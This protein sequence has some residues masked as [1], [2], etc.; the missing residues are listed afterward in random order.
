MYRSF[1]SS[2]R[3]RICAIRTRAPTA[4]RASTRSDFSADPTTIASV[5]ATGKAK[6]VHDTGRPLRL[7]RLHPALVYVS[8]SIQKEKKIFLLL[9]FCL[10][11]FPWFSLQFDSIHHAAIKPRHVQSCLVW[12]P[13]HHL[14]VLLGLLFTHRQKGFFSVSLSLALARS[15]TQVGLSSQLLTHKNYRYFFL[16]FG[17]LTAKHAFF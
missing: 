5:R 11:T 15:I 2:R 12:E 9:Y 4:R 8:F 16:L 13:Y 6:T 17:K 10:F 14:A 1:P 3:I 7:P